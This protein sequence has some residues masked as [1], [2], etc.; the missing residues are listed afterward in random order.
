MTNDRVGSFTILPYHNSSEQGGQGLKV[1]VVTEAW[2]SNYSKKTRLHFIA[3]L[4][5]ISYGNEYAK[6]PKRLVRH[7]IERG[8]QSLFEFIRFP[9]LANDGS[10]HGFTIQESLRHNIHLLTFIEYSELLNTYDDIIPSLIELWKSCL[11]C[12][13]IETPIF[14]DRQLVRHR[15]DS[16]IEL[17]RRY[18]KP[19]KV[20]FSYW[21]PDM[22]SAEEKVLT[23]EGY[24]NL[25]QRN[26]KVFNRAELA[27]YDQPLSLYTKYYVLRDFKGA[28]NFY[29]RRYNAHAQKETRDLVI[30][31]IE[32]IKQT[33]PSFLGV[34][35]NIP[36][37]EMYDVKI[38]EL[39]DIGIKHDKDFLLIEYGDKH[40]YAKFDVEKGLFVDDV[41][42]LNIRKD[43]FKAFGI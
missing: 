14:V 18:T 13:R 24:N 33:Q 41:L 27:R 17:S 21:F 19:D 31:E 16:R 29:V 30:Q 35:F 38:W 7:L 4:A 6:D 37:L 28:R 3:N 34:S 42:K 26:L 11:I 36:E 20:Q 43:M 2:S 15:S 12:L 40:Y 9:F 10:L 22:I 23:S 5:S 39:Q 8:H 1:E 25:Y 32:A